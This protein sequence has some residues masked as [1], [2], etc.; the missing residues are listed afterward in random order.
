MVTNLSEPG[1]FI[2]CDWGST[3]FR[4]RAVE[5]GTRRIL[6]EDR[7]GPG[8]KSFA[9]LP[10]GDRAEAMGRLLGERTTA[11]PNAPLIVTGMASSDIGWR[12]LP[13]ASAPFPIDGSA[14]NVSRIGISGGS[15]VVRTAWLVSGL[16]TADDVMRGEECAIVGAGRLRPDLARHDTLCLLAGTHPKHARVR[17]GAIVSFRT[18]ITG[19]LFEVL[20]RAS[21][22]SASVAAL[23][24]E[25]TSPDSE[26][27]RA[28]VATARSLGLTAALF[29]VRVRRL[30]HE[31]RPEKNAWFL[32]GVLV[33]AELERIVSGTPLLLIGEPLRVRL[34]REALHESGL[35]GTPDEPDSLSSTDCVV[36]GQEAILETT[37]GFAAPSPTLARSRPEPQPD[38]SA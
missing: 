28:G 20:S 12:E 1:M 29:Q 38:A 7:T 21:L 31:V 19:E 5:R 23:P 13:Y 37:G 3:S 35:I 36:A 2:G 11:W 10:P 15:G 9:E 24:M 32:S 33:G 25:A 27:F 30:L 17:G 14:A 4:L 34:Y 6:A 22:L 16:R 18:S 8:V 26:E